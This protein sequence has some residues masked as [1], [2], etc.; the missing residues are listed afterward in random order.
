LSENKVAAFAYRSHACF[1][2]AAQDPTLA[3]RAYTHLLG[4]SQLPNRRF[5]LSRD[6]G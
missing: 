6:L 4:A 1:I 5:I 2:V 3:R